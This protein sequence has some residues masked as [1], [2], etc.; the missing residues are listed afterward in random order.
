[1]SYLPKE[2]DYPLILVEIMAKCLQMNPDDR[3]DFQDITEML[4]AGDEESD[5]AAISS[6]IAGATSVSK[7]S[8]GSSSFLIFPGVN[9]VP[10]SPPLK[11][12]APTSG[13]IGSGSSDS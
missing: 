13:S 1:M 10:L 6:T 11:L 5:A 9:G 8:N 7:N 2:H 3:I 12:M 4:E